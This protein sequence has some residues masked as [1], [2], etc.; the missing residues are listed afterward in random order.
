LLLEV[1]MVLSSTGAERPIIARSLVLPVMKKRKHRPLFFIDIAVPRDVEAAVNDIENVYLY[2]IDDLKGLSQAHLSDRLKESEH[3]HAIVDA[4]I[5]KFENWLKQLELGPM[6]TQILEKLEK[7]RAGEVKKATQRLK[8][9]D[10][11]TI[12]QIEQLSRAIVNKLAHPHIMMIKRNGSPLVLD[13]MKGLFQFEE[14]NGGME[15]NE[16]TLDTGD[17]GK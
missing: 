16:R 6:I 3:A 14:E 13:M 17:E 5:G 2:D 10:E 7:L 8:K 15:E 4:E 9:V 1:D 12:K 11:D